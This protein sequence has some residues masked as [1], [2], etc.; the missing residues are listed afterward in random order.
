M[1]FFHYPDL[2]AVFVHI[3]KTGGRSIR[4][5]PLCGHNAGKAQSEWKKRFDS[6]EFVFA[7]VR[8]PID[9]FMSAY[10]MTA[11]G[12]D[13]YGQGIEFSANEISLQ[14]FA[15]RAF[16]RDESPDRLKR[17][18][19]FIVHHTLPMTHEY[20]GIRRADFIGRFE[21]LDEDWLVVARR[22]GLTPQ[23]PHMNRSRGERE[24]VPGWLKADLVR[25]YEEDFER[26]GYAPDNA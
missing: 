14:D 23:L 25:Y 11:K 7:F 3:P 4:C 21:T 22:L 24:P 6:A 26:F 20:Y 15:R 19:G 1:S 12:A 9:R 13:N 18:D 16:A 17:L 2:K 8:H 10:R 5:G